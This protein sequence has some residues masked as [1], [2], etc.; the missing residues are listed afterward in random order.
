M[1]RGSIRPTC[2]PTAQLPHSGLIAKLA[3]NMVFCEDPRF[4]ELHGR[5]SAGLDQA[6]RR[7]FNRMATALLLWGAVSDVDWLFDRRWNGQSGR[8]V[9]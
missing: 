2:T 6:K 5:L 3:V 1:V 7:E 4:V 8:P 9:Y